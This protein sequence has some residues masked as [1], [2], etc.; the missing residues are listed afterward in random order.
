MEKIST[1]GMSREDWLIARKGG[2]GGSD[3]AAVMGLNPYKSPVELFYEKISTDE[4]EDT[5]SEAAY[6]GTV[7]EEPIARRFAELHSDARVRRNNHILVHPEHKFLF[8]NIDR[9]VHTDDGETY[10]L[11]IKTAGANSAKKWDNGDTPVW[12]NLQC[13]HYMGV[14]GWKKFVIAAL[15]GGQTYVEREIPR[16]DEIIANL[17]EHETEFWRNVVDG[18]PPAWDGSQSAWDILRGLYPKSVPG[19]EITLPD[20]LTVEMA[21]YKALKETLD[22]SKEAQ[23]DIEKQMEAVKQKIA[24]AMGDAETGTAGNYK[25]SYKTISIPEKV[26]KGYSYRRMSVKEFKE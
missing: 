6:W 12:Y 23:K 15:I 18:V 24:A 2:I 17:T 16:D 22:S 26:V 19:K 4:P 21:M 14:T 20:S 7:L 1:L 10:G 9:E 13:Q 11:E 8:A 3:A 25:V 5:Q